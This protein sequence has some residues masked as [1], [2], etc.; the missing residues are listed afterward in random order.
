MLMTVVELI[1]ALLVSFFLVVYFSI[2]HNEQNPND[3]QKT[4]E[5]L[6][7]ALSEKEKALAAA[8]ANL[9]KDKKNLKSKQTPSCTE[10]GFS[11]G[12]IG[13]VEILGYN[14]Y[15]VHG[16]EYNF[17]ELKALYDIDIAK[18]QSVDCVHSINVSAGK[19]LS[20]QDYDEG[21][22]KIEQLFYVRRLKVK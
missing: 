16:K 6:K 5:R 3:Q 1:F 14:N 18:A 11:Q 2:Q 10:K 7:I 21:L 8:L 20:T 17:R 19:K 9:E 13:E 22:R 4:I 15:A 12:P